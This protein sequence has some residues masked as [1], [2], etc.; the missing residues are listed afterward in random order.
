[1]IYLLI[2]FHEVAN[3]IAEVHVVSQNQCLTINCYMWIT[4]SLQM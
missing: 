2:L 1:M 4:F 3:V